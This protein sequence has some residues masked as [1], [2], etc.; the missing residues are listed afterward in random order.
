MLGKRSVFSFL[1]EDDTVKKTLSCVGRLDEDTEGL[2]II[3]NDGFMIEKI[4]NPANNVE[5][6]YYAL[7]EKELSIDDIKNIESGI[8]I[9][10]EENREKT[11][12]TTKPCKVM[13]NK[14]EANILLS[15]GKKRE[16]RKIF[17]A[18][19]NKVL[20]LMRFKIGNLE[21]KKFGL[22]EGE[23]KIVSKGTINEIF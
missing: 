12:Y 3:T 20:R 22:K 8:N 18:V 10:L 4:T 7:L 2:L 15:E 5:K 21:L 6:G 16:V 23:Y 17:E 13:A 11:L 14:N 9:I 1:K 19:G